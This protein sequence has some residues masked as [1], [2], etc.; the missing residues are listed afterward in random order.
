MDKK[1]SYQQISFEEIEKYFSGQMNPAEMHALEKSALNDPFLAEAME[2]YHHQKNNWD[3]VKKHAAFLE[4]NL[5]KKVIE[6]KAPVFIMNQAWLRIAAVFI[7]LF[8]AGGIAWYN[9]YRE[10]PAT[11]ILADNITPSTIQK[12]TI[13]Q[14]PDTTLLAENKSSRGKVEIQKPAPIK[15]PVSSEKDAATI[16]EASP[17]TAMQENKQGDSI[18][19]FSRKSALSKADAP[20]ISAQKEMKT[21]KLPAPLGGL[22]AFDQYVQERIIFYKKVMTKNYIRGKIKIGFTINTIGQPVDYKFIQSLSPT[23]DSLAA[24]ILHEGPLW[25]PAIHDLNAEVEFHF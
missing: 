9:W 5:D 25:T 23:M 16:T 19:V 10:D 7:V 15:P 21:E 6:K 24:K 8:L 11:T 14:R 1:K 12:D 20:V 2:G 13:F 4:E 18:E 3:E 22:K 17:V